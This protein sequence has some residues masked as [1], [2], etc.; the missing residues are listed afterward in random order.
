M[1][2]DDRAADMIREAETSRAVMYAMKGN[3][4]E[5]VPSIH[6]S[7]AVLMRIMR[8]LVGILTKVCTIEL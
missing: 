4:A 1:R 7:A 5:P 3:Y 6:T 2:D 8:L